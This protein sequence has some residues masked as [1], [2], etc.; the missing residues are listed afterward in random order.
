MDKTTYTV[1]DLESQLSRFCSGVRLTELRSVYTADFHLNGW[2]GNFAS[3]MVISKDTGEVSELELRFPTLSAPSQS[4]VEEHLSEL[5]TQTGGDSY[6]KY[7]VQPRGDGKYAP[8]IILSGV[9]V[10]EAVDYA[11]RLARAYSR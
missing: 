1:A 9:S 3:S 11:R 2:G 7:R 8:H 10:S 5:L 4:F 6:A